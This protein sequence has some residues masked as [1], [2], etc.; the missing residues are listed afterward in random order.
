MRRKLK[1]RYIKLHK[2]WQVYYKDMFG[3][4][5]PLEEFSTKKQAQNWIKDNEPVP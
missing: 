5:Q 1:I 3:E 2:L 4:I